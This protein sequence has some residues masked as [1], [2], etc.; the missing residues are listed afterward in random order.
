[1]PV[2]TC[3][4]S[5]VHGDDYSVSDDAISASGR[6]LCLPRHAR[7]W[8][9][10]VNNYWCGGKYST[11]YITFLYKFPHATPVSDLR[12]LYSSW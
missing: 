10:P 4:V 3:N 6:D 9:E 1:M 7:L 5:L 12:L 8:D 2:S 11:Q